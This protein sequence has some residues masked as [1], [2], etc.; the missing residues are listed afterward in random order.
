MSNRLSGAFI[1]ASALGRKF[2]V[3]NSNIALP[4]KLARGTAIMVYA[5][6]SALRYS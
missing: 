3:P 1:A 6:L 5:A 2:E 4:M